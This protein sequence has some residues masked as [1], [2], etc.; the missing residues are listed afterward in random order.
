M[1]NI[2]SIDR[3][4][5]KPI[6][7]CLAESQ[8]GF[9]EASNLARQFFPAL[10]FNLNFGTHANLNRLFMRLLFR[11]VAWKNAGF[12]AGAT[13]D[14]G[15]NQTSQNISRR[16]FKHGQCHP[17]VHADSAILRIILAQ[18]DADRRMPQAA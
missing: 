7:P 3:P 17:F 13:T 2:G 10:R 6:V 9:G 11:V 14:L 4:L 8:F 15:R 5:F 16:P 1:G 18:N 12:E